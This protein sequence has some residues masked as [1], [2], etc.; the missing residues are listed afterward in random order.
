MPVPGC[1]EPDQGVN[2]IALSHSANADKV[3]T[4]VNATLLSR[5]ERAWSVAQVLGRMMVS[6]GDVGGPNRNL[7]PKV[8]EPDFE[9]SQQRQQPGGSRVSGDFGGGRAS[10]E[11][12]RGHA[13]VHTPPVGQRLVKRESSSSTDKSGEVH[14][15]L[16]PTQL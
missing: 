2:S 5:A 11:H 15:L 8:P 16:L 14:D 3:S 1:G 7:P 6:R 9:F 12:H 10:G 4:L 13:A